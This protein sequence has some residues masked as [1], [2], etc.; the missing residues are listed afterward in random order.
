MP[1]PPPPATALISTGQPIL[2]PSAT[3]SSTEA[4]GPGEPGTSGRPSSLAVCLATI[5]SPIMLMCCG[6]GPMKVKPCAS[7]ASAKRAFSDR[8]P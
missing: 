2:A 8:K 4:T 6:V 3:T 1:R 7:T 5:L